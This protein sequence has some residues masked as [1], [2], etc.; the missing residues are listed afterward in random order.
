[1]LSLPNSAANLRGSVQAAIDGAMKTLQ[2]KMPE[3]ATLQFQ[4]VGKKGR[5]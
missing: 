3:G 5:K 1:M 2:D 4:D